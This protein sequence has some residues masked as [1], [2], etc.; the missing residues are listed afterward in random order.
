LTFKRT[1]RRKNRHGQIDSA[2]DPDQEYIYIT[3]ILFN[4]SSISFYSKSNGK[5]QCWKIKLREFD[6]EISYINGKE[7]RI[8]DA[9]SRITQIS[10]VDKIKEVFHE[11]G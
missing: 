2:I 3:Y 9:L 5:L 10:K 8:A 6:F 7:N 11:T 1:K 4:E